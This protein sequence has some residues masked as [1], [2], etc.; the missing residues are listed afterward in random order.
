MKQNTDY[1]KK[2]EWKKRVTHAHT[3]KWF[4]KICYIYNDNEN[5]NKFENKS[6]C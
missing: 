5:E 3:H 6:D 2:K 4:I 1:L